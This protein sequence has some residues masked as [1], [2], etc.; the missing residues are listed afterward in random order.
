MSQQL[1]IQKL[2]KSVFNST[3][4]LLILAQAV[5]N[6]IPDISN[7]ENPTQQ[8]RYILM[9]LH[10][11]NQK[12]GVSEKTHRKQAVQHVTD[13]QKKVKSYMNQAKK[14]RKMKKQ[15]KFTIQCIC[16]ES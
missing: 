13:T 9:N 7:L 15:I 10:I 5:C 14:K 2:N 3:V 11:P 6:H 1:Q 16:L 12:D 4:K 8:I